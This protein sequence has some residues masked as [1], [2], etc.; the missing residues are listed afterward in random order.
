[1]GLTHATDALAGTLARALSQG[2]VMPGCNRQLYF[3]FRSGQ[4]HRASAR[5]VPNG[6]DSPGAEWHRFS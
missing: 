6:I 1:M 4:Y 5:P 2:S 3:W